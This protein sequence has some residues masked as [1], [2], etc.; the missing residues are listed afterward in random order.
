VRREPI[1]VC[2]AIVPWNFP[3]ALAVWKVVPAL[4]VGN[5]VV[6]K[7]DE[8]TPIGALEFARELQ[9]AGLPDGVLNVVTGDG[10]IVGDHLARHPDVR[11]IAFTG[12]TQVG[13]LVAGAAAASNLKRVTLELGGKSPNIVLDDA[14]L[15]M[16]VDG[17]IWAFLM[18][19]G[20]ACESG[21]RLLLPSSIHDA[22]VERLVE[23]LR[24]VKIGDPLDQT[25]NLGPLISAEQ[26]ER[27]LG[28][29]EV[30][31]QEGATV[32]CGGGVPDG[33]TRGYFVEPTVL[34]DVTNDMTVAREEVFGPVLC[35]LK[36]DTVDEAIAIA[37]DTEYGLAAGVWSSD[38]RR[39]MDVARQLEAGSVWI[40][41]WHMADENYPFGGYKQSGMGREL[42]HHSLAE[43]TE[44]K[45]IQISLEPDITKR[46]YGLALPVPPPAWDA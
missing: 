9:A 38:V 28:Y 30:A 5:S 22:F 20:Q 16:A 37:N 2:A 36:Y 25:T 45:S 29:I 26:R 13:K 17:A 7:T 24:T 39:A 4:A 21:T 33:A 42:G 27:V 3:L 15:T 41:D 1:G 11:K 46:A 8:K 10:E 23:R 14:D 43:Y 31:K 40:N 18:H 32:A 34:T 12:S 44:E 19:A 6:L 35:V